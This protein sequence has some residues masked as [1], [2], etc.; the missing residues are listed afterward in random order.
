MTACHA[1]TTG[2]FSCQM[3]KMQAACQLV[4]WP[5]CAAATKQEHSRSIEPEGIKV[6]AAC[7]ASMQLSE[8]GILAPLDGMPHLDITLRMAHKVMSIC[9]YINY[10]HT[11]LD[12]H[13]VQVC[14]CERLH[15]GSDLTAALFDNSAWHLRQLGH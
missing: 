15:Q 2:D 6:H 4:Q 1:Y 12:S 9:S 14:I 5:D 13:Q 10:P 3:S 8:R 7:K 11:L